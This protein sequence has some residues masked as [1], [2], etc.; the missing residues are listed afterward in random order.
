[1]ESERPGEQFEIEG[2]WFD[3]DQDGFVNFGDVA[4]GLLH[5]QSQYA[6]RYISGLDRP[7]LAEGLRTLGDPD[8]Y[9]ELRIHKDDIQEFVDR[10]RKYR[11]GR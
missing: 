7:K 1:M 5:Q 11:E 3:V 8:D 10:V 2:E 6:S 4:R 9:H